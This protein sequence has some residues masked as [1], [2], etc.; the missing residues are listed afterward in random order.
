MIDNI[1]LNAQSSLKIKYND[2][3]IYFDPFKIED[4]LND[5][6]YIFITHS[7]YDHFSKED[8]LK[9]RNNNT[10]IVVPSDLES[11]VSDFK[12][13]IIVK[14]NEEYIIDDIKFKTVPAYNKTKEFHKRSNN[15]VGYIINL[16]NENIYVSGDT[17]VVD[18]LYDISC[19]IACICI[20]GYYTCDYIEASKL[21]NSIKPKF[22]I[23]IHYSTVVGTIEDAYKFKEL[24]GNSSEVKILLK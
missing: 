7:H 2:K 18:E 15:W 24:V 14:P 9:V 17:D 16:N 6:D 8:I 21:I 3:I 19:D 5:A 10:K 23:P 1:S 4:S 13:V 20:G 11:E 12:E 22:T